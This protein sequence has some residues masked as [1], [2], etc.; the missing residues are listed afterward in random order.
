MSF[1]ICELKKPPWLIN[2]ICPYFT[3]F[4]IAYPVGILNNTKCATVLDPFSGRGTTLFASR[5]F[6]YS[7]FG[8]DSNPV[9][10]AIT[11]A[12]LSTATVDDIMKTLKLALNT[13]KDCA[14]PQ[15]DFWERA[16]DK[17]V[18]EQICRIRTY[19]L[20]HD[21]FSEDAL[22]GIMLGALHGPKTKDLNNAGYLG[23]QMPR[24]YAPKPRYSINYWTIH[25]ISPDFVAIEKVI[26]KRAVR[27][28][29]DVM[30]DINY[31][32]IYGDARETKHF[33]K[34]PPISTVITS[35]PYYGMTTYYTDQWLRN[36][37]LGGPDSPVGILNKQ[38]NH[39][40]P[41]EF[42]LSLSQVWNNC[43]KAS[44]K[45]AKMY[46]RYGGISSRKTDPLGIFQ[47]SIDLTNDAWKI[48][49]IADAGNSLSGKRQ[50]IQMLNNTDKESEPANEFDVELVLN[51]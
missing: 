41:E 40:S 32:I 38:I 29:T 6:G 17:R 35:P 14:V 4:P 33:E 50:A 16:Y 28:Y 44:G 24:T 34:F 12:K 51:A 11:K 13:A 48:L 18:L 26:Y 31:Q 3:M 22:R 20:E 42:S 43:A 19:L 7:A 30:P 15:S 8:I 9:A 37:F 1:D 21:G 47:R 27:Y 45:G 49:S 2:G 10:I 46:V 23:N 36:W 5:M 39:S 25:N